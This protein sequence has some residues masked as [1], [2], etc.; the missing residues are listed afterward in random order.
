MFKEGGRTVLPAKFIVPWMHLLEL[1]QSPR[2]IGMLPT[3]V[4]PPVPG[5]LGLRGGLCGAL[6]QYL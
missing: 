1:S 6:E 3:Y 4:E 5:E 2:Y